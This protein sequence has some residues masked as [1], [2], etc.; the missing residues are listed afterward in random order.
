[1]SIRQLSS[2]LMPWKQAGVFQGDHKG[3][4]RVHRLKE[5]VD[6]LCQEKRASPSEI[7]TDQEPSF[8]H[9]KSIVAHF[10]KLFDVYS[11]EG[12]FPRMNEIYMQLGETYNSR[13][14][15]RDLLGLGKKISHL[16]LFSVLASSLFFLP[17][18]FTH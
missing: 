13:N 16:F 14:N 2:H 6:A 8:D 17:R 9:L 15:M 10:Q 18:L 11:I 3:Y 7:Q 5:A 1:M 4:S 12:I